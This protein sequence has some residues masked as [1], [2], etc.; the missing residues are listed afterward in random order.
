MNITVNNITKMPF[1]LEQKIREGAFGKIYK[2]RYNNQQLIV[3]KI[4][5]GVYNDIEFQISSKIESNSNLCKCLYKYKTKTDT[6]LLFPY[7]EKGDLL[8]NIL[9]KDLD[10]ERIKKYV[11]QMLKTIESLNKIG[12]VHL[13]IKPENFLLD[14]YND[15][16]LADF[17][18]IKKMDE[19]NEHKL[20]PLEKLVGTKAYIPPEFPLHYYNEKSD[21]WS[22]G[23]CFYT[24]ISNSGLYNDIIEYQHDT[25]I[26]NVDKLSID[27]SILSYNGR[28]L[29][30]RMLQISPLYRV[31]LEA[32][33]NDKWFNNINKKNDN[34]VKYISN[35]EIVL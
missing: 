29:L 21:I 25:L 31:S 35:T 2:T 20:Y 14:K 3:K 32:A 18:T 23:V 16:V 26:N 34:Y 11:Y 6:Y 17:S 4:K 27:K 5:N 1:K 33:L 24:L 10:E 15:L 9:D 8:D 28:Y 7:Y 13:D 19:F 22:I 30:R 12:Y